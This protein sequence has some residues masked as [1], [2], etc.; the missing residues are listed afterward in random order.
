[1]S[2]LLLALGL[3][4][5]VLN[6]ER[7]EGEGGGVS[8]LC[9]GGARGRATQLTAARLKGGDDGSKVELSL[10]DPLTPCSAEMLTK[11]S[12]TSLWS[13]APKEGAF[14][15]PTQISRARRDTRVLSL[16]RASN[17]TAAKP[18]NTHQ[19]HR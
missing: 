10:T 2:A 9:D 16:R 1:M 3:S 15:T 19:E 7:C 4:T 6:V 5:N 17:K 8:L 18:T 12:P 13:R 14:L 11:R